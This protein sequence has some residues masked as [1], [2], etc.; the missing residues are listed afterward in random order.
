MTRRA[1]TLS[2]PHRILM[3]VDAVGG[4]W[5]YGVDLCRSLNAAG[6]E[7]VL[8]CLGPA[9]GPDRMNE[10]AALTDTILIA[11]DEPLDWLAPSADALRHI[12]GRLEQLA[13]VHRVALLH[14]NLPSQAAGLRR[15]LPVVVASH[16]CVVTWWATMRN[17]PLPHEWSW[18]LE[19]NRAGLHRAEVV[20]APTHSHAAQ[21]RD[22]YGAT[23]PLHVVP[24]A[25]TPRGTADRAS[26]PRGHFVLAAGRW[27]DEGKN[28]ALLD[29]V[30]PLIHAPLRAAGDCRG[31]NGQVFT[32]ARAV[33][34]GALSH[35]Q[36]GSLM[37][38]ASIFVSPSLYEPFGLAALEAAESGAALVLSDIPTYRELW[39]GAACFADPRDPSAFAEA[40]NHL[41]ADATTCGR[42]AT[43]AGGRAAAFTPQMQL[44]SVLAAYEAAM[45]MA[46]EQGP[47]V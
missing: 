18:Q 8:A 12:A 14:L 36:L 28:G 23:W 46:V 25:V 35:G 38:K 5:R 42:M 43:R 1:R 4:V 9:P 31:A 3:T 24:N 7:V 2:L 34:E 17:T 21:L 37:D 15:G 27:W 29:R 45:S 30:A 19:M 11:V 26:R 10:L 20:L 39:D 47:L 33:A 32:F 6:V 44:A 22:A 13:D 40:I 41:L 16:S